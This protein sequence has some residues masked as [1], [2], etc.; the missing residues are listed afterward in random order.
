MTSDVNSTL[1]IEIHLETL[2]ERLFRV[3]RLGIQFEANNVAMDFKV[4][5]QK[6]G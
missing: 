6:T 3:V 1:R 5:S 4:V 2:E